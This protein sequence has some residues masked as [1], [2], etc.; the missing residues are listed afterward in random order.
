MFDPLTDDDRAALA[1]HCR[2][3]VAMPGERVMHWRPKRERQALRTRREAAEAERELERERRGMAPMRDEDHEFDGDAALYVVAEGAVDVV[4]YRDDDD[5][6]DDGRATAFTAPS[7]EPRGPAPAERGEVAVTL[8]RGACF[9]EL[10]KIFGASPNLRA[11][12]VA[13]DPNDREDSNPRDVN[14]DLNPKPAAKP[15]AVL[16]AVDGRVLRRKKAF[17]AM[18]ESMRAQVAAWRPLLDG[19]AFFADATDAMQRSFLACALRATTFRP[20]EAVAKEGDECAGAWMVMEG[21]AHAMATLVGGDD[22]LG[23]RLLAGRRLRVHLLPAWGTAKNRATRPRDGV[24]RCLAFEA[25][26]RCGE[27]VDAARSRRRA[28]TFARMFEK[29]TRSWRRMRRRRASPRRESRRRA[30]RPV[31]RRCV[32]GIRTSRG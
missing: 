23:R 9:G 21:E 8:R 25:T 5:D 2:R 31:P 24:E 1:R 12:V 10:E 18:V 22:A 4:A 20:R 14:P 27:D 30:N 13:V 11:A 26:M 15:G 3:V 19:V 6:D 28:R 17:K 7:S 16:W 32:R 29:S